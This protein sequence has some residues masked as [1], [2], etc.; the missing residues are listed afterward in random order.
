MPMPPSVLTKSALERLRAV[1]G[2]LFGGDR[3]EGAKPNP[4]GLGQA[5]VQAY[6]S[7]AAPPD[8]L[9]LRSPPGLVAVDADGLLLYI[10]G[11]APDFRRVRWPDVRHVLP[12]RG[13]EVTIYVAR[14][15]PIVAPGLLAGAI[16][17]ARGPAPH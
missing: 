3:P 9:P 5:L 12:V 11:G 15:G 8:A 17:R 7:A 10:G 6:G 1:W 13:N 2:S 16:L 4:E 14:V